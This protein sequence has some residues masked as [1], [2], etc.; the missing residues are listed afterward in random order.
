MYNA[1]Q[2]VKVYQ[3]FSISAGIGAAGWFGAVQA[4]PDRDKPFVEDLGETDANQGAKLKAGRTDADWQKALLGQVGLR[5]VLA[6]DGAK[7]TTC[8]L[9]TDQLQGPAAAKRTT[10]D[11]L[12]A[13]TMQE[14]DQWR[15]QTWRDG[16]AQTLYSSA[17][18][19]RHP[20]VA[21]IEGRVA[22]ACQEM[23]DSGPQIVVHFA[24][25]DEIL[26]TAGRQPLLLAD[27][28]RLFMLCEKPD[29][30]SCSL[31]LCEFR[32]GELRRDITLPAGDALNLNAD[33]VVDPADGS[34]YIVHES[35]P[36]WGYDHFIG[37]HRD[38]Y[39][40]RLDRDENRIVASP[41][42]LPVPYAASHDLNRPPVQPRIAVHDGQPVVAFRRFCYWGARPFSWHVYC[43]K[44]DGCTWGTPVQVSSHYGLQETDYALFS[45][46]SRLLLAYTA[47]E[48]RPPLTPEDV[49]AG[50]EPRGM[51][52][53]VHNHWTVVEAVDLQNGQ[54]PQR[55][56]PNH[57][58]GEYTISLGTRDIAPEP[59]RNAPDNAPRYLAWGDIHQHTLWSKC[60]SPVDGTLRENLRYQRDVLGCR[61]FS[62]AEHTTMMSDS[63]FT[64][65][66]DEL[67]A[68]AGADGVAL[69][70]CEPWSNGHDTNLYAI[71]REVFQRLRLIYMRHR[72][73]GEILEN[74]RKEFPNREVAC[75]RHFHGGGS[76]TWSTGSP[77]VPSTHM[78]EIE[79][80]M[81][82][83]QI[84]GNVFLGETE[85]HPG[86][87][88]FPVNFLNAGCRVG[89]IGGTDHS[90]P[91][92]RNNHFC[93]TGFWVEEITP[94]AVW[95]ALWNR[96]TIAMSNGKIAI[97]TDCQ[98][99]EMG[100]DVKA[101]GDVR[102]R[103]WLSSARPIRRVTLVR[104]GEILGWQD[105]NAET[106]ELELVDQNP[107]SG[108]HWY[109]VTAEA[110]SSPD[111]PRPVTGHSSPVFINR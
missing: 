80:A 23:T 48:Q 75:L 32:N 6:Q 102:I 88:A 51:P 61:V 26:R 15:L 63:E 85:A 24:A 62:A 92:A 89:L 87:P 36:A 109:S 14:N 4:R 31:Q 94:E 78:P 93:L 39:L 19:L 73:L 83:M 57:L 2:L 100:K 76:G 41:G 13:W 12:L 18:A 27:G 111:L 84:R 106:A 70:G 72:E 35:C 53:R 56:L 103:A 108:S 7:D 101:D 90:S 40:W 58:Q 37:R 16:D 11:A 65:Y 97:W 81:E 46:G 30:D 59:P 10:A 20:T 104:D 74:I 91:W 45:D 49:D 22:A 21:E 17:N 55:L 33:M 54:P 71:D 64:Y 95:D 96:R 98:G 42:R 50:R 3:G 44:F 5:A 79:P 43:M 28:S 66:C 47:C 69:Y 52:G 8:L 38:L 60:M 25:G 77:D 9:E 29:R 68:E 107:A 99:H 67:A 110:D 82:A 105:V 1:K 86:L 34:L